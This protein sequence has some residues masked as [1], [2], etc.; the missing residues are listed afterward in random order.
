[1]KR[2]GEYK[3]MLVGKMGMQFKTLDS[4][5][6][7]QQHGKILAELFEQS[8]KQHGNKF[9]LGTRKLISREVEVSADGRSFEKLH[10]G[11][12]EWLIY[13]EAFISVCNFAS[14]VAQLG[15]KREER[16]T[17]FADTREE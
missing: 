2:N 14:G 6:L 10:F 11:N 7:W 13:G 15:R 12:Y 3:W 4:R 17:I 8:C 5:P 9:L 16:A 1:M